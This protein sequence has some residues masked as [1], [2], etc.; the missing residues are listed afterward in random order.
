MK[1]ILL[2]SFFSFALMSGSAHAGG[3]ANV[4]NGNNDG[5]GSLRAALNSGASKIRISKSVEVISVTE[6]LIYSGLSSLQIDGSGQKID[7]SGLPENADVFVVKQGADLSM[8]DLSI[9]GNY[10]GVNPN[11]SLPEGG[12]GI[13]VNVPLDRTGLVRLTLDDVSVTRVGNHG[14]HVSD[15]TLGDDCASGSGGGGDGSPASIYVQLYDVL[16]NR[17]GFGKADADGIRV[18]DRG[19]GSIYMIARDSAFINVG[20]DG[21]EVDEGNDGSIAVDVKD[22]I[23]DSNGEYCNLVDFVAGNPCDDEGDPDVDDGF[24]IDEA[25]AG[26]IYA[27]VQST[28]VTNNFDEGLDFDE[29]DDGNIV[30]LISDMQAINN[31]DEGIKMSELG[32]GGI[33]ADIYALETADNNGDSGGIKLEEAD[34]GDVDVLV[35]DS[36]MIGGDEEELKLEQTDDG[37]GFVEV[38]NSDLELDLDGVT[39]L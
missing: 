23:F 37:E 3:T 22:S 29:Q 10:T 12:K 20:A 30:S 2:L 38:I 32:N 33:N 36:K 17:V 6:S 16:I 15:C 35:V 14:V 28:E 11:P 1:Q 34:S 26:T 24:D 4:E 8:S 18:D 9:I 39:E 25:G 27:R 19:D 7:G 13:F 21:I 31:E 5:Y